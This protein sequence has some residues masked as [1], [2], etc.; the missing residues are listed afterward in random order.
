MDISNLN[1][2]SKSEEGEWLHLNHPVD[3]HP[4]YTGEGADADSGDILPGKTE[5]DCQAVRVKVRGGES[6]VV[7]KALFKYKRITAKKRNLSYAEEKRLNL[8]VAASR[9]IEME[10]LSILGRPLSADNDEDKILLLS[11]SNDFVRQIVSHGM[12]DEDF[13]MES[14]ED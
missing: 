12:K 9:I 4:L 1:T 11:Q 7:Q 5:A 14:L 10:N 6:D 8:E 13:M 2:K 3:G